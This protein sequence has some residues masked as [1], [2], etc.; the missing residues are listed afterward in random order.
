[1][2]N[3]LVVHVQSSNYAEDLI[4]PVDGSDIRKIS[5]STERLQA[6]KMEAQKYRTE[7]FKLVT[8]EQNKSQDDQPQTLFYGGGPNIN[9]LT[10]NV[11]DAKA[12]EN[13]IHYISH[14]RQLLHLQVNR[15]RRLSNRGKQLLRKMSGLNED[16]LVDDSSDESDGLESME[17][18][19]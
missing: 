2:G 13:C 9:D 14:V 8:A 19:R 5:D 18:K 3:G 1:M 12:L 4:K 6:A 16:D 7:L 17:L 11:D 10:E 15:R